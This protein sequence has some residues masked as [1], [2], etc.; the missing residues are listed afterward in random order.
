M[1][2][3]YCRGGGHVENVCAGFQLADSSSYRFFRAG[4]GYFRQF[5]V[6]D[7]DTGRNA[8]ADETAVGRLGNLLDNAGYAAAVCHNLVSVAENSQD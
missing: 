8:Y 5:N 7:N 3:G 4:Y 6:C 2:C 1:L